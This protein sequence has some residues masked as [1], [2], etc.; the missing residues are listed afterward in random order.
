MGPI[1]IQA[2]ALRRRQAGA[3]G[4]FSIMPEDAVDP[5]AGPEPEK[6]AW[7]QDEVKQAI[8]AAEEAGLTSY[9][10]KI[11]IDGAISIIVGDPADTGDPDS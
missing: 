11:E 6:A 2:Q 1:R 9:R 3:F 5:S 7:S 10:V 4:A 8:A